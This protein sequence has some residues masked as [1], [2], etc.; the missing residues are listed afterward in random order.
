MNKFPIFSSILFLFCICACTPDPVPPTV[1]IP[2]TDTQPDSILYVLGD[3]TVIVNS[4]DSFVYQIGPLENPWHPVP[5]DDTVSVQVDV[6]Q[7]GTADLSLTAWHETSMISP[8]SGF[9][10]SSTCILS[11]LNPDSMQLA[12]IWGQLHNCTTGWVNS[13]SLPHPYFAPNAMDAHFAIRKVDSNN[14]M[15]FGWICIG[16][17]YIVKSWAMNLIPGNDTEVGQTE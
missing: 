6:D 13:I 2:T 1:C 10:W 9:G 14:Q 11:S 5:F 3:T 4:I 16:K 15:S 12:A 17:G 7:N 8:S